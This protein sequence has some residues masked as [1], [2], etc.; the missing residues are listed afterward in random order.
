MYSGW[1]PNIKLCINP[2]KTKFYVSL[3]GDGKLD[4]LCKA[5]RIA[6]LNAYWSPCGTDKAHISY[7]WPVW[8]A[9]TGGFAGTWSLSSSSQDKT[10]PLVPLPILPQ[11]S[12]PS[13]CTIIKP[14]HWQQLSVTTH[15]E[16]CLIS[17][18][19]WA[20]GNNK[21]QSNNRA[22]FLTNNAQLPEAFD[23]PFY[24][25]CRTRNR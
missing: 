4:P 14:Q 11:V 8:D 16:S 10:V 3:G 9:S 2:A 24:S 22:P 7:S 13:S 23:I 18:T 19:H 1:K 12:I 15:R 6:V 17:D 5:A 20:E 21:M 25:G